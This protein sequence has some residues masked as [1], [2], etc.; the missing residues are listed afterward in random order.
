MA[1]WDTMLAAVL[2]IFTVLGIGAAARRANWLTTEADETLFKL[3]VRLLLPALILHVIVGNRALDEPRNIWLPPL[4]GFGTVML[5]FAVAWGAARVLK[6]PLRLRDPRQRRTFALC[7]GMYNY[8]YIPLPLAEALFDQ[9]TVGVLFVHNLGVEIALWT[10]GILVASGG[11]AHGWWRRLLNPPILAIAAALVL[12]ALGAWWMPAQRGG[13]GDSA[14]LASMFTGLVL[15]FISEALGMLGRCAIPVALLMI[16]ATVWD[17]LREAQLASGGRVIAASWVLRLGAL[18]AAFIALAYVLPGSIELK[19]V[20]A[21]EAAMPAAVFPIVIAR[22][23]HGDVAT[24]VRVVIGT[25]LLSLITMPLWLSAA[26]Q[27]LG[28]TTAE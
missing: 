10:V 6:G 3:V 25:S 11:L 5:G 26:L 21:L 28:L 27:V 16:G 4:V 12:N 15:P 18:P 7:N 24:A 13:T 20:M 1:Q 9:R 23:Y 17:Y 14:A 22:H 19:R 2:A 8:G